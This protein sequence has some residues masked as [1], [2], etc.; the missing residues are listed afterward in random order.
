MWEA[1][2]SQQTGISTAS[3]SYFVEFKDEASIDSDSALAYASTRV[4]D[5]GSVGLSLASLTATELATRKSGASLVYGLYRVEAQ[6][7]YIEAVLLPLQQAGSSFVR[8]SSSASVQNV[9]LKNSRGVVAS[10]V[11]SGATAVDN[12]GLLGLDE[13]GVPQGVDIP[14]PRAV[15]SAANIVSTMS[16]S[17][18]ATMQGIVGCVNNATYRGRPAGTLLC[19]GVSINQQSESRWEVAA[20]FEYSA[21]ETG[22]VIGDITVT[23]KLGWQYLDIQ[24]AKKKDGTGR[25]VTVPVQATVHNVFPT[26]NF[27]TALGF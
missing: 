26:A 3:R 24:Y 27:A 2:A 12:K 19:T 13:D 9:R 11:P 20:N 7:E 16:A 18:E 17:T 14:T 4:D 1:A 6:Y 25:S 5:L 21:N 23:S 15:A 8:T 10:Y 22:I